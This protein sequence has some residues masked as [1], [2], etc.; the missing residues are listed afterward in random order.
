MV[1]YINTQLDK[2]KEIAIAFLYLDI[3]PCGYGLVQHPYFESE[4]VNSDNGSI[5]ILEDPKGR[6]Y[7]F[8][9]YIQ[10]INN[11]QSYIEF[12][13]LIRKSYL[14]TFLKYTKD[15]I[16]IDDMSKFLS[17]AY[18]Q[19]ENPNNDPNMPK[20]TLISLFKKSNKELIMDQEEF[21]IYQNLP[22]NLV[23]YR[24]VGGKLDLKK[25]KALSWTT[26]FEIAKWFALRFSKN[27]IVFKGIIEHSHIYS[28]FNR[29]KECVVDYK[30]INLI[31]QI[32][33]SK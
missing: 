26:D 23:I 12:S 22:Q 7:I 1:N 20:S 8:Q 4:I 18:Q 14:L 9:K 6:E 30:T 3:T 29:E 32:F 19:S 25:A 5:N 11:I 21:G 16:S 2:V 10:K 17:D 28:Y 24:G 27:G 33:V 15:Y 13:C 31:D